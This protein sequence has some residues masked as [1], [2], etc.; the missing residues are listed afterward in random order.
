LARARMPEEYY[1]TVDFLEHRVGSRDA[2]GLC[3]ACVPPRGGAPDLSA[4]RCSET[5]IEEMLR[6]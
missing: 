2:R 5:P 3:V 4:Q 1:A 6:L